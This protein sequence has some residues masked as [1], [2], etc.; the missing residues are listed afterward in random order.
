MFIDKLLSLAIGLLFLLVLSCDSPS[1]NSSNETT[2]LTSQ[3]TLK[4]DP[5]F[6]DYAASSNML[7][8]EIGQLAMEKGE[9]ESIKALGE[10]AVKFHS[11]ALQQL[12]SITRQHATLHLPDSLTGAD[13][14]LVKEF[15]QLEGEEFNARYKAFIASTHQMQLTR[16]KEALEKADDQVTRDWLNSILTHLQEKLNDLYTAD[17]VQENATL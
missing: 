5:A 8:T 2:T 13:S 10:K 16:Y 6:W 15:K 3:R 4:N 9:P 17:S 11:K 7:Q 1:G 12:K 14:K